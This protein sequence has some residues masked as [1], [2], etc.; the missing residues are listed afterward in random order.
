ME[1]TSD[2]LI[3]LVEQATR[4]DADALQRLVVHYHSALHR[5]VDGKL[6]AKLRR[7]VD[8]EDVL[9]QAYIVAFQ[10]VGGCDFESPGGFY[11]WLERIALNKLANV[12][13]D[14]KR[15]KRDIARLALG[16]NTAW[17]S[18]PDLADRLA[19]PGT[20][21]TRHMARQEA[22]AAVISSVARLTE[23]QREVVRMR[24]LEGR[25]VE[26]IAAS[27]IRACYRRSEVW[28]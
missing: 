22:S 24:F 11:K 16:R 20:T 1:S 23:D 17:T 8:P 5:A 4:G 28:T 13:R 27:L 19:S 3:L 14:L 26:E 12:S 10:G 7:Y 25:P 2:P 15:K 6:P 21:P 18:C 9:Q